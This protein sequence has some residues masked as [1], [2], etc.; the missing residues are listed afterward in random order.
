MNR[1]V[2]RITKGVVAL[3]V[4]S[5]LFNCIFILRNIMLEHDLKRL[6]DLANRAPSLQTAIQNL[7]NDL[8][9]YGKNHTDIY[10]ILNK[11][12]INTPPVPVD[13]SSKQNSSKAKK[14]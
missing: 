14:N 5:A 4:I 9:A 2:F 7:A 11:F 10:P 1:A 3:L 12:G 6:S 13:T 8:L